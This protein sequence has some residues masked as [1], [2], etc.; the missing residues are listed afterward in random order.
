MMLLSIPATTMANRLIEI[1]EMN[2][3]DPTGVQITI[4]QNV[5]HIAGAAGQT[6]RIYNVAGV[7]VMNVVVDGADKHYNLN[8]DKG[9]YIVKVGKVVR[10]ISVK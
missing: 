3:I 9:C 4:S 5:L 1:V 10:K 8:L 7:C 6:L 2:D